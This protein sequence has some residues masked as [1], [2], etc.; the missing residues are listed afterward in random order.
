MKPLVSIVVPALS[1]GRYLA[2]RPDLLVVQTTRP[3]EIIATD[4]CVIDGSATVIHGSMREYPV[5]PGQ[6]GFQVACPI[7]VP[8]IPGPSP[9][10]M[11][12]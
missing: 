1:V 7:G 10:A 11:V 9:H 4:A 2:R 5:A 8:G 6:P 3:L 12:G